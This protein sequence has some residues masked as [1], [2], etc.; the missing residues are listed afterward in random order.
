MPNLKEN[1]DVEGI[2]LLLTIVERETLQRGQMVTK[3][4]LD[5][6]QDVWY[7]NMERATNTLISKSVKDLFQAF[8]VFHLVGTTLS[9][10]QTQSEVLYQYFSQ[11]LGSLR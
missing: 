9:L 4:L 8:V 11:V 2:L 6:E 7:T 5:K 10:S 1:F 3:S